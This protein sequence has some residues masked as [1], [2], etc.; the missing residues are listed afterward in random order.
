VA[1]KSGA[2]IN[3]AAISRINLFQ[4]LSMDQCDRISRVV[5]PI[6]Y[7]PEQMLLEEGDTGDTMVLIFQGQVEVTKRVIIRTAAGLSVS[8]KPIIR[9][10]TTDPPPVEPPVYAATVHV[11]KL[12]AFGVGEFSL[13]SDTAI[14]TAGVIAMTPI[15]AGIIKITAFEALAVEDPTIAAPVFREVARSAVQ[16]IAIATQDISNLTQAFFFALA[17]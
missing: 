5:Q 10:E 8:R 14:R 4:G 2:E 13:V 7:A 12:P 16:N 3:G 6:D 1:A 11:V 9:L 15:T 17:K